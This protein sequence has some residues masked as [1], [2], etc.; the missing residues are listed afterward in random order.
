MGTEDG[1]NGGRKKHQARTPVA[2]VGCRGMARSGREQD[3]DGDGDP[4]GGEH[5]S[6]KDVLLRRSRAP[7]VPPQPPAPRQRSRSPTPRRRSRDSS[8]RRRDERRVSI[9]RRH[10]AQRGRSRP[11]PPPPIRPAQPRE[12][13]AETTGK[14]PVDEFFKTASKQP[15]TSPVVDGMAADVQAPADA[16]LAEP[17]HFDEGSLL[18]A[19]G[20]AL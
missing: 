3:G 7:A 2:S 10:H 13:H 11:P 4:R 20:E 8:G 19:A 9:G 15:M 6:W 12:A 17:L 5:C 16:V 14:D 1:Q 18:E